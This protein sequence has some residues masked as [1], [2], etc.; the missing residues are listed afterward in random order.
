MM[1]LANISHCDRIN[2]V[3]TIV[4]QGFLCLRCRFCDAEKNTVS[5]TVNLGFA[6]FVRLFVDDF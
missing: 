3:I 5:V 1:N 4:Y 2:Y 6:S